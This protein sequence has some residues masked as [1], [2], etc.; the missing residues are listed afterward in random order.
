MRRWSSPTRC[1]PSLNQNGQG[2]DGVTATVDAD[3]DKTHIGDGGQMLLIT[4]E[5]DNDCRR[6]RCCS[7][8]KCWIQ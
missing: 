4:V 2:N 3:G 6:W 5:M 8:R 1:P 7:L